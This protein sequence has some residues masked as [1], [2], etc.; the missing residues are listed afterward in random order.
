MAYP[1][2]LPVMENPQE[3][4]VEQ[5]QVDPDKSRW[6]STG[7]IRLKCIVKQRHLLPNFL[8]GQYFL[9]SDWLLLTDRRTTFELGK[10]LA[11]S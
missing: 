4:R 11:F 3:L 1:D 5:F 8:I 9:I 7:T 6:Q 2:V 10:T